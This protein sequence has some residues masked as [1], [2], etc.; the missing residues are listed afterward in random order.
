MKYEKKIFLLCSVLFGLMCCFVRIGQDDAV[1]ITFAG[2]ICYD[3]QFVLNQYENWS[4]RSAVNFVMLVMTGLPRAAFGALMGASMYLM[5][6]AM[7]RLMNGKGSVSAWVCVLFS[8]L[9][10]YQDLSGAGWIA[11][12]TTYLT[13]L[14]CG[15]AALIPIRMYFNHEKITSVQ[16]VLYSLCFVYGVNNEQVMVALL[17]AYIFAFLYSAV[18]KKMSA[19]FAAALVLCILSVLNTALCQGNKVRSATEI[20]WFPTFGMMNLLD[21]LELGFSTT[22]QYLMGHDPLVTVSLLWLCILVFH[23]YQDKLYRIV[24]IVLA[25]LNLWFGYIVKVLIRLDSRL[26]ILS[27][28]INRRGLLTPVNAGPV[29]LFF[30]FLIMFISLGSLLCEIVLL[31]QEKKELSF[32]LMI[33]LGGFGSRA[34]AGLS[35]ASYASGK[36]TCYVLAMTLAVMDCM[37]FEVQK[38]KLKENKVQKASIGISAV[39]L[40]VFAVTVYFTFR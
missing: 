24:S 21:K 4:S 27:L 8:M 34:A 6:Y 28:Q 40:I 15:L 35:P 2:N 39:C 38:E 16:A 1:N 30:L 7:Y 12:M 18:K 19:F 17:F 33:L 36:R 20:R 22:M 13:P 14:A 31:S 23:A 25:A 29:R 11:T 37:L 5:L 3:L 26:D 10:S 9:Y 32:L